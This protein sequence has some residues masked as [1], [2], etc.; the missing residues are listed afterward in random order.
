MTTQQRRSPKLAPGFEKQD[1]RDAIEALED[2]PRIPEKTPA[3]SSADGYE[4][5]HCHDANYEYFYRDGQWKRI[6][7]SAF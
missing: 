6:A 3:A 1:V 4:G 2:R 5:E 7:K